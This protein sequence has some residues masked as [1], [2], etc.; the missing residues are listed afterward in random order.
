MASRPGA[1]TALRVL[2][3]RALVLAGV[4][5]GAASLSLVRRGEKRIRGDGFDATIAA[6]EAVA[7]PAG[8]SMEVTNVADPDGVYEALSLVADPA[9]IG[10]VDGRRAVTSP[11]H[12][13]RLEAGFA[14]A[15]IRAADAIFDPP[16]TPKPVAA[17]RVGEALAWL[18]AAGLHFERLRPASAAE[19]VRELIGEAPGRAWTAPYVSRSL[20]MSEATLRRR[21][22]GEGTTLSDLLVE[23]RM[24]TA[25]VLLQATDRPVAEI[26]LDVG[27]GSPS[28]FAGRFRK[29]F[30]H[31]PHAVRDGDPDFE[32]YGTEIDRY[33]SAV[34]PA[35]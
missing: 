5:V 12:L 29:R 17:A 21:L 13:G 23:V 34:P 16:R 31:P 19:R 28:R 10:A 20:G 2:Q 30:G 32:R 7:L 3:E 25:L 27:Y 6:G 4:H 26:A 14:D 33:R 9:L 8:L 22:A 11:V 1:G 15:V 18:A 24:S 35:A